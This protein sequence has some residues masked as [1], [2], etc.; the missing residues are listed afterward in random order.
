MPQV[1]GGLRE[2]LLGSSDDDDVFVERDE[3][4]GHGAAD[5]STTAGDEGA[6]EREGFGCHG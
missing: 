4:F 1:F 5:A 6:V 3:V 2:R